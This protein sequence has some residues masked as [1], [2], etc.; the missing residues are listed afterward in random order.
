[1]INKKRNKG[2]KTNGTNSKKKSGSKAYQYG[3][4]KKKIYPNPQLILGYID[5]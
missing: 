2:G 4:A 5:R 1:M 3:E